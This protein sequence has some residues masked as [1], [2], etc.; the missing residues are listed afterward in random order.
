MSRPE[1]FYS[2]KPEHRPERL[3][4]LKQ[5]LD[6]IPIS[7]SSWWAGVKCG[8]YPAPLKLSQRTTVWRESDIRALIESL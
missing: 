8:K 6:L 5:V 1:R 3:L 4:R 2:D 7:K